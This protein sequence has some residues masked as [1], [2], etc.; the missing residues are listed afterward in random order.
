MS[1]RSVISMVVYGI[2]QVGAVGLQ[3]GESLKILIKSFI[4]CNF[5]KKKYTFWEGKLA[6]KEPP[7]MR[8][9]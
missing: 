7:L 1:D 6:A 8:G 3:A 5:F 9:G 2:N 4:F